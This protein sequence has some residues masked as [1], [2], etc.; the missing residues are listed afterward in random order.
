MDTLVFE[1]LV[2]IS[3]SG[4]LVLMLYKLSW[5]LA[6]CNLTFRVGITDSYHYY[7]VTAGIGMLLNKHL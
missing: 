4:C 6:F 7:V 2:G 5:W 3:I 1:V